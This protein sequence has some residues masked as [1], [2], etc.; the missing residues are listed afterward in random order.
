LRINEELYSRSLSRLDWEKLV[1]KLKPF[2]S[3]EIT[4]NSLSSYRPSLDLI[5]AKKLKDKIKFLLELDKRGDLPSLP[6]IPDLRKLFAK[7]IF[8]GLF[9]PAELVVLDTL[10][11]TAISL[12]NLKDSPF[13]EVYKL[14]P[15][16]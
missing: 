2:V 1:E 6:K 10:I 9:L 4:Q 15:K 14:F 5:R 3:L 12:V 7:A 13:S 11:T 16:N 8:R